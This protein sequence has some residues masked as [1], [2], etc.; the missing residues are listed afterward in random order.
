MR[1]IIR[2]YPYNRIYK[3]VKPLNKIS[4]II[5]LTL[6]GFYGF[7]LEASIIKSQIINNKRY[8]SISIN[9]E[10]SFLI[11]EID[12]NN[13]SDLALQW[14]TWIYSISS[15]KVSP[16][17]DPDGKS[18]GYNQNGN[19]WFLAGSSSL[20]KIRYVRDCEIPKDKYIFFPI[21]TIV[22]YGR[23][24]CQEAEIDVDINPENI[25]KM[26]LYID[27]KNIINRQ[28]FRAKST[29]CFRLKGYIENRYNSMGMY[30]AAF[31]GYWILLKPLK[32]GKHTLRFKMEYL[33]DNIIDE[34][35]ANS[36]KVILSQDIVYNLMIK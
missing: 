21:F 8:L 15:D 1:K 17:I 30:P 31:D 16:I 2:T 28:K 23:N 33:S 35:N 36:E 4:L 9:N 27:E 20:E 26:D 34:E 6:I 5:I 22:S 19:V 14:Y 29:E 12:N 25:T 24:I 10:N 32:S 7:S 18:C 13:L 11:T 3:L